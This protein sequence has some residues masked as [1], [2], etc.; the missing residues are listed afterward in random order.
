[1]RLFRR[2]GPRRAQPP[3]TAA[4]IDGAQITK[5]WGWLRDGCPESTHTDPT[6]I[7]ELFRDVCLSTDQVR[8]GALSGHESE[9]IRLAV[10]GNSHTPT[11]AKWGDGLRSFGLAED[12]SPWVSAT[13]LLRHPHPP[14]EIVEAVREASTGTAS[15]VRG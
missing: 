4:E 8:L 12:P 11:W 1:M 2:R 10:A 3:D 9:W 13:V 5:Y 14:V 6:P 15:T 7:M